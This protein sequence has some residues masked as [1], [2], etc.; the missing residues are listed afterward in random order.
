MKSGTIFIFLLVFVS[1]LA[2]CNLP[3]SF[4]PT[5]ITIG[6]I[7]TEA[8]VQL[9]KQETNFPKSPTPTGTQVLSTPTSYP[10][11]HPELAVTVTP[12]QAEVCPVEDPNFE[13][14]DELLVLAKED[15]LAF[16]ETSL[17]SGASFEQILSQL[18]QGD[19][20][21]MQTFSPD[22]TTDGVSEMII[23]HDHA[24]TIFQ[25]HDGAYRSILEYDTEEWSPISNKYKSDIN[26]NGI[27]ELMI[28]FKIDPNN[29]YAYD[30]L[31]WDGQEMKAILQVDHG[32]NARDISRIAN[33]VGWNSIQQVWVDDHW[34][35]VLNDTVGE[36][37]L[38]D[39]DGNGFYEIVFDDYGPGNKMIFYETGPWLYQRLVFT[40]NGE[41]F[42]FSDY[43]IDSPLYRYQA[44][45][46]ADRAF[47]LRNYD[48]ALILYDKVIQS[49]VL[50]WYSLDRKKY[51][52]DI[53][54][55]KHSGR[56]TS[57]IHP[58]YF[59]ADEYQYLSAYARF[60]KM[61]LQL[62]AGKQADAYNSY[63]LI[64]QIYT[65]K[66]PGFKH[67]E[68][69]RIYWNA[70]ENGMSLM[71]ACQPVIEYV[72]ENPKLMDAL[73][74]QWHGD[75]SHIYTPA[76]VCPLDEMDIELLSGITR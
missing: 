24:V 56:D 73:G 55:A 47:L 42:L 32:Y 41:S 71:D 20:R 76:D 25:C 54:A 1:I 48:Q 2:A 33:G 6:G 14:T 40:W 17:D 50:E 27:P 44:L 34:V 12:A 31:E 59:R 45:Q 60:R 8:A 38:K 30:L 57:E 49:T 74:D 21:K 10:T 66:N 13:F 19:T 61:V 65:V 5:P 75:Q 15:L 22:L 67:A 52:W 7:Q 23:Q 26:Q 53:Y 39:L 36:F 9:S 4:E 43:Q 46:E 28:T 35:L 3:A 68:I 51:F 69:G 62:A 18:F 16:V 58:P 70:V 63:Q 72:A 64:D 11:F 29:N 37:T